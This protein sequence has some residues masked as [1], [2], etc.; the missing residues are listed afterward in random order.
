MLETSCGSAND[1]F[2]SMVGNSMVPCETSLEGTRFACLTIAVWD[3]RKIIAQ[4]LI[5]TFR[6]ELLSFK[7]EKKL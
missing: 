7:K 2:D 5:I 6:C 4:Q 3:G 1:A